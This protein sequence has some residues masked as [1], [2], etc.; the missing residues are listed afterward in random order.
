MINNLDSFQGHSDQVKSVNHQRHR[1]LNK[2]FL[3]TRAAQASLLLDEHFRAFLNE[4]F[5]RVRHGT[6]VSYPII[7]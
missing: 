5:T 4:L 1:F 2:V 3:L 6:R 7:K